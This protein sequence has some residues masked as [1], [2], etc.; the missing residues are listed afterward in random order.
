MLYVHAYV[1]SSDD[2]SCILTGG[3]GFIA[4]Q[5]AKKFGAQHVATAT[6]G[7]ANI[8]FCHSLGADVVTDYKAREVWS[9]L[10]NNSVNVVYDNY[11]A[12]GTA[13]KAM[14]SLSPNGGV[15]L[16]LPG[17]EDG[18][19]SKHPKAGVK[20]MSFGLMVPSLA[21]LNTVKS[22]FEDGSLKAHVD[23]VFD[24]DHIGD[25]FAFSRSGQVVGKIAI[26]PSITNL[27]QQ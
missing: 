15:Y 22:F 7:S 11:G 2:I 4:I 1:R 13:D 8:A 19:L 12:K 25:A 14:P 20:Q 27:V 21:R 17:G 9:V 18:A 10:S 23:Q 16:L 24:F 26:V 6:S 5:L 3:T